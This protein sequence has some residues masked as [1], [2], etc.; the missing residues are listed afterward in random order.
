[1]RKLIKV[2]VRFFKKSSRT[3]F[4]DTSLIIFT[5]PNSLNQGFA[6]D[7]FIFSKLNPNLTMSKTSD[8][9]LLIFIVNP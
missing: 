2:S 9:D 3:F 8:D 5:E 4:K 6:P 1:N 7:P